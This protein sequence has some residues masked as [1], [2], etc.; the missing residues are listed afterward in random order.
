MSVEELGESGRARCS[1][2]VSLPVGGNWGRRE[3]VSAA[4]DHG[5]IDLDGDSDSSRRSSSGG[6][7]GARNW[8]CLSSLSSSSS[9][10]LATAPDMSTAQ[11]LPK[12]LTRHVRL[13]HAQKEF[14]GS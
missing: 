14:K 3:A 11:P 7:P 12:F 8:S 1:L 13:G 5:F 4:I 2:E 9:L 6:R 10:A